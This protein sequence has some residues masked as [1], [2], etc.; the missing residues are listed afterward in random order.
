MYWLARLETKF[1]HLAIHG[2]LKYVAALSSL[3]FVLLM[4]NPRYEDFL[5]LDRTRLLSGEVWRIFT[6]LFIPRFGG[7][8]PNWMGMALYVLFLIWIGDGLEQAWGAFRFNVFFLLGMLGTAV[9]G[10]ISNSDPG[11][12]IL[13]TS[14]F[15]AFARF[16]PDAVIRLFFI[17]PVKVKWLAWVDGAFMLFNFVFGDLGIK[18]SIVAGMLNYLLFFGQ[19]LFSEAKTHREV[20]RRRARFEREMREGV[21]D[22][23]HRCKVC[24]RTEVTTPELEFRVAG[25]GE[26]YC[27]EHLPKKAST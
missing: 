4:L 24:G 19:E 13:Y 10:L 22:T 15:L 27:A 2:L 20:V 7:L 11:G 3:C 14:I 18:L 21:E 23:M 17:L 8:F 5:V 25:D 1:G 16:Y 26:E 9:G 6:Y 12:A